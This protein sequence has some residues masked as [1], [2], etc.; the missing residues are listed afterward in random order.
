MIAKWLGFGADILVLDCPT[1][2]IDIG[3]KATIY[4]LMNVLRSRGVSMI[5]ISEELS[6]IIGM[7]DRILIMK[8]GKING[9]FL[10]EE[11]LN[12]RKLIEYMV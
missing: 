11:E 8:E 5:L 7:S 9:E 12:E 10:R 3:V 1:R 6:E 2:G 4:H